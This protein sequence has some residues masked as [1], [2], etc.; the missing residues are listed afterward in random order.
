MLNVPVLNISWI[1]TWNHSKNIFAIICSGSVHKFCRPA[2][3][4][5]LISSLWR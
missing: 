4:F 2:G 5:Q 1:P 3:L